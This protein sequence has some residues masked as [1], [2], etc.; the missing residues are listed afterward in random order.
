MAKKGKPMPI[1]LQRHIIKKILLKR[2][3]TGPRKTVDGKLDWDNMIPDHD[4]GGLDIDAVLDNILEDRHLFENIQM[5]ESEGFLLPMPFEE[6]D[7]NEQKQDLDLINKEQ[8]ELDWE[9]KDRLRRRLDKFY[10]I[11]RKLIH[12]QKLEEIKRRTRK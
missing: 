5:L 3:N 1:G 6:M 9:K 7:E 4:T 12:K 10:G 2:G 11:D 8:E